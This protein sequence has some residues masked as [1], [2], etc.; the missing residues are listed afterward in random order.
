MHVMQAS[1]WTKCAGAT[2]RPTKH[3]GYITSMDCVAVPGSDYTY[4]AN[5]KAISFVVIDIATCFA[6]VYHAA[7]DCVIESLQVFIGDD[8]VN[9]MYSDHAEEYI[10]SRRYLRYVHERSHP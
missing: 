9:L 10:K 5:D 7:V 2:S 1:Q 8:L 6:S 3:V 4:V